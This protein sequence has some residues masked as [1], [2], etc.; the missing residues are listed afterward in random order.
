MN[1]PVETMF[2]QI[3]RT[4]YQVASLREASNKLCAA[5]DASGM[6]ASEMGSQFKVVNENGRKV[7]TVSYN[8]RVWANDGSEIAV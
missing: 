1:A 4:R 8:G 5:R 2:L 6:G 7:A 3:G